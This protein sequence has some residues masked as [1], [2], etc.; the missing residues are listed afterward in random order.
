MPPATVVGVDGCR[1]GWVAV[2]LRD[3]GMPAALL[4]PTIGA[5]DELV[6]DAAVVAIDIPIGLP[7]AGPRRADLAAREILGPRKSSVFLTPIRAALTSATHA[8]ASAV[9]KARTGAGISQQAFALRAKIFEVE[10]WLP[11]AK[12]PRVYEVHP[13]VSFAE[14]LGRP[15]RA[16]KKS[17]H[18]V[19]ERRRTL[20]G[21]GIE[22]EGVDP[23]VGSA[24]A[25]D[26]LC[27]AA[28]VAW[29]ALRLA[30]GGARSL[31]D[32]PELN[33]CGQAMA[34]WV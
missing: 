12:C 32:P 14:L 29:S 30:R 20:T 18:G 33:S 2:V 25:V 1:R 22:L 16:T 24:I 34:I 31:P 6:P 15:A 10:Q 26:D 23:T 5:L 27:D 28:V 9:A 4:L 17:W 3:G 7:D 8:E 19:V 13:E 11:T 21:A